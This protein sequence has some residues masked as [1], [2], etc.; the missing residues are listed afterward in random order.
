MSEPIDMLK[1]AIKNME[2]R[3]YMMGEKGYGYQDPWV[4]TPTDLS[5]IFILAFNEYVN[6][7]EGNKERLEMEIQASLREMLEDPVGTW[8]ALSILYSY[9]FGYK[10]G[11]LLFTID[12]A[13][14][15]PRI[16]VSLKQFKTSLM[17]SKEWVGSRFQ[18]GL[19]DDVIFVVDAINKKFKDEGKNIRIE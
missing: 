4:E 12:I 6:E 1:K 3:A 17:N 18:N 2:L 16:N 7:K 8:W 11:S 10:V 15:I 14:L 13:P 9:F 5:S 19:W